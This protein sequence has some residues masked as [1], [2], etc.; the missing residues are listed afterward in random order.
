MRGELVDVDSDS[1]RLVTVSMPRVVSISITSELRRVTLRM[2]GV[3]PGW[4]SKTEAKVFRP[5]PVVR[6][7]R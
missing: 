3:G 2:K 1:R 7:R 4:A 5:S 6:R